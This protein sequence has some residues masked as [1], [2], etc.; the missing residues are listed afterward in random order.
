MSNIY[1]TQ[2]FWSKLQGW[3]EWIPSRNMPSATA[4]GP[5]STRTHSLP[6][7]FPALFMHFLVCAPFLYLFVGEETLLETL[8]VTNSWASGQKIQCWHFI[9]SRR[10]SRP[11]PTEI[12]P[13]HHQVGDWFCG[14]D[15]VMSSNML[16]TAVRYSRINLDL[17]HERPT[18]IRH[19]SD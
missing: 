7:E 14:K 5:P 12:L 18:Y 13:K 10:I 19:R 17:S 2:K 3:G 4:G 6:N 11:A 1:F 16:I 15:M 9:T 8:P